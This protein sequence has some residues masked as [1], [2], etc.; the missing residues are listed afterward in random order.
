MKRLSL[1]LLTLCA[2][3]FAQADTVVHWRGVEGVVTAPGVDNPVGQIHSGAGPW[4]TRNGSARIDLATGNGS[5]DVEG[6][7][8]NGGNASGTPGTVASVVGTL[9]CNA[10]SP[11]G[12]V[13]ATVDTPTAVLSADGN[14]ELSFKIG[15]PAT[16]NNPLFLIRVPSG[17]WIATGTKPSMSSKSGY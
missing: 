15:V 9:V 12:T 16:C 10:G 4:T 1:L 6:L 5:F 8:L 14:A 13:E 17:R 7:V 3:A 2:G 11:A